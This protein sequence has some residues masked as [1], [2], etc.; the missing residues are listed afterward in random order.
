MN[1]DLAV[2][3]GKESQN[4]QHDPN[5]CM[6]IHALTHGARESKRLQFIIKCSSG[7]ALAKKCNACTKPKLYILTCLPACHSGVVC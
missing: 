2:E 1:Y 3:N 7:C 4:A 5:V 6:V